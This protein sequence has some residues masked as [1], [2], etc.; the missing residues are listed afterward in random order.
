[1]AEF[2]QSDEKDWPDDRSETSEISALSTS[3]TATTLASETGS[4]ADDRSVYEFEE[5]YNEGDIPEFACSYCNHHDPACVAKCVATGK[6]FCNGR[7]N[8][9]A[10]H[11]IQH[12]VRSKQKQV[13]L[14]PDSPLGETVLECYACGTKNVF[15]LGY[16]PAKS[17]SVVV[18]LCR[19][20][21][22]ATGA[23]KDMDWD[24]K[25]WSPLIEDRAFVDWLIK[26]PS[27]KEQL[28]ARQMTTSQINKMEELW[29]ENPKATIFD[30]EKP[31]VDEDANPVSTCY[32]PTLSLRLLSYYHT[33]DYGD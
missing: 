5:G 9:N 33:Y 29:R 21:C 30:L 6:W 22:L 32:S 23:L 25:Q 10:S 31:G 1:M 7:G 27:E 15:L 17:D 26:A 12:L 20:P 16:I 14:H 8:T 11:L 18:L 4:V 19:E 24:L 28:R 13:S 3:M 2:S